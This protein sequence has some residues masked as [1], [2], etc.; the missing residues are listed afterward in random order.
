[1]GHG[2]GLRLVSAAT[3]EARDTGEEVAKALK[4]EKC[5]QKFKLHFATHIAF[6]ART[7]KISLLGVSRVMS[8]GRRNITVVLTKYDTTLWIG[9]SATPPRGARFAL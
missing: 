3:Q 9:I 7:T 1:M 2:E 8:A 6:D 5:I 4:N